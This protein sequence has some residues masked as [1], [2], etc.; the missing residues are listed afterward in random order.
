MSMITSS[1][2]AGLG[3]IPYTGKDYDYLVDG[4]LSKTHLFLLLYC[5]LTRLENHYVVASSL[6]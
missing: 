2:S 6:K 3:A 1:R 4:A 5:T